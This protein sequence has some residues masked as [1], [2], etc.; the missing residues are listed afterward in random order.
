MRKK[1]YPTLPNDDTVLQLNER[2]H[3]IAA[4]DLKP[5][6]KAVLMAIVERF[7]QV[8]KACEDA[9]IHWRTHYHWLETDENYRNSC[10]LAEE[11]AKYKRL[12]E[13][14]RR[15]SEGVTEPV[16][17]QGEIC[18]YVQKYSDTLLNTIIKG[19]FRKQ[20]GEANTP[21]SD[22]DDLM[23]KMPRSKLSDEDL[24]ALINIARK[25]NDGEEPKT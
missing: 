1:H 13:A 11:L 3:E 21:D 17:Y 10:R 18:G 12:H 16:F 5:K 8:R 2:L 14:Y 4:S 24:R 19:D 15:A 9:E 6:Q 25:L 7:G 22:D 23:S 20:Y